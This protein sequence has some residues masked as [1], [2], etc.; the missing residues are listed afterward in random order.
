[1][2]SYANVKGIFN[3]G[4]Q[5]FRESYKTRGDRLID[6]PQEFRVAS[7]DRAQYE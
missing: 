4:M 5:Y 2:R 3:F 1:M 6:E 7:V